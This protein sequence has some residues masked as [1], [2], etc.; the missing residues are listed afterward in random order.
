MHGVRAEYRPASVHC[1]LQVETAGAEYMA[2]AGVPDPCRSPACAL[3][4]FAA[5]A[6]YH[7]DTLTWSTGLKVGVKMGIHS[8]NIVA[9]V[10]GKMSPRFRLFGNCV[11]TAARIKSIAEDG[12]ILASQDHIE[13]M[14]RYAISCVL[15][16][17]E[18]FCSHL[19]CELRL[20]LGAV[21]L[22]LK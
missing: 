16:L 12:D 17:A 6:M 11:H 15:R 8:G 14:R 5:N 13:T 10:A 19:A 3:T 20:A 2:A 1:L 18:L 4:S 22:F 9:G 7:L 21:P